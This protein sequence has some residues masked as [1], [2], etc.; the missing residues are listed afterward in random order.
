MDV[1]KGNSLVWD[2]APFN[3]MVVFMPRHPYI[4]CVVKTM[5]IKGS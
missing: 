2:V 4:E 3:Y 1:L 5:E